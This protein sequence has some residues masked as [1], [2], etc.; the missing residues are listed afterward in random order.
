LR[1]VE[2]APFTTF[3]ETAIKSR[4]TCTV[5]SPTAKNTKLSDRS[6]AAIQSF[7]PSGSQTVTL[8]S[9]EGIVLDARGWVG[10]TQLNITAS[11]GTDFITVGDQVVLSVVD[12]SGPITTRGGSSVSIVQTGTSHTTVNGGAATSF[13]QISGAHG[14]GTDDV[15]HDLNA[16][17]TRAN[18]I[19]S[20][21]ITDSRCFTD[22]ESNVLSSLALTRCGPGSS[23]SVFAATGA[24]TLGLTLNADASAQIAD[25]HATTVNLQAVGSASSNIGLAFSLATSISFNDSVGISVPLLYAP[26]AT[27]LKIAGRG[28]FTGDLTSLAKSCAIDTTQSSGIVT[29]SLSASEKFTGGSGQDIVSIGAG[30][31]G[32]VV[33][34]SDTHNEIVLRDAGVQNENIIQPAFVSNFSTLGIAGNTSGFF[35]MG[36]FPAYTNFDFQ[37]N[38]SGDTEFYNVASGSQLSLP[39][40]C[41]GPVTLVTADADATADVVTVNLG[42]ANSAGIFVDKVE[43][44]G[45]GGFGI[46][47]VNIVSN[48][49]GTNQIGGSIPNPAGSVTTVHLSGSAGVDLLALNGSLGYTV[50]GG[51]DDANNSI[52]LPNGGSSRVFLGHGANFVFFGGDGHNI[53]SYGS[54]TGGADTTQIGWGNGSLT[55][56]T[57]IGGAVLGDRV[58]MVGN[59]FFDSIAV[60]AAEVTAAGGATAALSLTGWVDGALAQAGRDLAQGSAGWFQFDGNTY[61]INQRE[62]AGTGFTVLDTLVELVGLYDLS[63][64]A[65]DRASGCI[66]L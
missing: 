27:S 63:G 35:N 18:S 64:G 28:D 1:T 4:N 38:G 39:A 5:D 48:G 59:S 36:A 21:S 61:I 29:V 16:G 62:T 46:G 9:A 22:I 47:T 23:I 56:L 51:L 3:Q 10:L 54:H 6:D 37:G 34:G 42:T 24:R 11:N 32:A 2:R 44:T 19:S 7:S 66:V 25:T 8:S 15:I 14:D 65:W 55:S 30:H 58:S 52:F 20:V 12:T 26:K 43:L 45:A 31:L 60:T 41:Q 57:I 53:V 50:L 13:V 33:G 40:N 49:S 17:T